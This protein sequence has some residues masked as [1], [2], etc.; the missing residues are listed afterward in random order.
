V[1]Q[2]RHEIYIVIAEYTDDYIDYLEQDSSTDA[3]MAMHEFGPWN[4]LRAEHMKHVS[5]IL[6][7]LVLRAVS[8]CEAENSG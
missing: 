4:T 2:D 8:D 1:S 3:Y 6:V 7:A 5:S